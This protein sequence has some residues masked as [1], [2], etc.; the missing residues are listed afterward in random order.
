[1]GLVIG[2]E[3]RTIK[4]IRTNTGA[5]V[6]TKRW[7]RNRVYIKAKSEEIMEKAKQE[8]SRIMVRSSF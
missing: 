1:M 7:I 4:Q 6:F 3:G 2:K 8:V 5:D